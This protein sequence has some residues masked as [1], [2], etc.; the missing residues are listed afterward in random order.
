MANSN[1]ANTV[2]RGLQ[3]GQQEMAFYLVVGLTLVMALIAGSVAVVVYRAEAEKLEREIATKA[4]PKPGEPG[5]DSRDPAAKDKEGSAFNRFMAEIIGHPWFLWAFFNFALLLVGCFILISSGVARPALSGS[6]SPTGP[7]M[8]GLPPFRIALALVGGLL[9]FTTTCFIGIGFAVLWWKELSAGIKVW[10]ELWPWYLVL[11]V[12]GGLMVTFASLVS[13]KS[14]E[15]RSPAIRR[16][17]YGFNALLVGFLLLAILVVGNALVIWYGPAGASDWTQSNIYSITAES[18]QLLKSL[19]K[20]VRAY[21]MIE[22][23]T[24]YLDLKNLLETCEG[25]SDQL[26]VEWLNPTS[27]RDVEKFDDLVKKY[28]YLAQLGVLLVYD[29]DGEV[30]HAFIK[31]NADGPDDLGLEDAPRRFGGSENSAFKGEQALM[32]ALRGFVEGTAKLV[33]YVTQDSGEMSLKDTQTERPPRF[34]RGLAQLKTMLEKQGYEIKEWDLGAVDQQTLQPRPIPD[35]A[36]AVIVA[37]PG[38]TIAGKL[39]PLEDYM[40]QRRGKMIILVEPRLDNEGHIQPSGLEKLAMAFGVNIG[41]DMVL[42]IG[43]LQLMRDPTVAIVALAQ[44]ADPSLREAIRNQLEARDNFMFRVR[45]VTPSA[46]PPSQYDVTPLLQTRP[47]LQL[48]D[49]RFASGQWSEPQ[50]KGTPTQMLDNLQKSR[51]EFIKRIGGAQVN[52]AVTVRE[53]GEATPPVHPGMPPSSKPGAPRLVVIGDATLACNSQL[54]TDAEFS[55]NVLSSSLSWLRGKAVVLG[56]IK[57]KERAS[58]RPN[59]NADELSRLRWVPGT[60]LLLFVV[61]AGVTVGILRRRGS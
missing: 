53:K 4:R 42:S 48:P 58:Y 25:Y 32:S 54:Q 45:S 61:A 6:A 24:L 15:R 19:D 5:F 46:Q 23:S 30:R 3:A 34:D 60:L 14:E 31:R 37:D 51:E 47:V 8:P 28:G 52:L 17:L 39:K 10:R 38:P 35:D 59:L 50:I 49:G 9:G 7:P 41:A 18:K 40:L 44:G 56:N 16:I 26:T 1:S 11:A 27:P 20:P 22:S 12:L 13:V 2:E 36:F 33:V 55:Y 29:S 21:V 57:P 43:G